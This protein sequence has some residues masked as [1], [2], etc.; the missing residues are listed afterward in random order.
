MATL[1]VRCMTNGPLP[2]VREI[3]SLYRA[4][5][6]EVICIVNSRFRDDELAELD[7]V[8]DRIIRVEMLPGFSVGHYRAWERSLPSTAD[9]VLVVDHDE[10]PSASF[11]R[12]LPGLLD[13]EHVVSYRLDKRWLFPD[14]AHWLAAQPWCPNQS[15]GLI[16]NDPNILH[17]NSELHVGTISPFPSRDIEGA[18][19]HLTCLLT[20][21]DERREKV[22]RY[23]EAMGISPNASQDATESMYVP[24]ECGTTQLSQVPTEDTFLI[25][26]VLS[27]SNAPGRVIDAR[28]PITPDEPIRSDVVTYPEVAKYWPG[29]PIENSAYHASLT[30]LDWNNPT[31]TDSFTMKAG[32]SM[33]WGVRVTNE[34]SE[35]WPR[36]LREPPIAL[37]S[38]WR[39]VAKPKPG[40]IRR[41]LRRAALRLRK[42]QG[43]RSKRD[44][45]DGPRSAFGADVYPGETVTMQLEIRAPSR[46]GD[47]RLSIDVVHEGVRWFRSGISIPV[48]IEG[49]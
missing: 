21:V 23:R 45:I 33:Q 48:V 38:R 28:Q 46:V 43:E 37:G 36:E 11:L 9:W 18:L 29:R 17:F 5:A 8:A 41:R 30:L 13:V 14:S 32:S 10:V 35:I 6:D 7:G 19:Y 44:V 3:L 26:A 1:S 49:R 2:R 39:P 40:S 25:D 31:G 16:R 24:E 20:T 22:A 27:K 42:V 47:Y 4:V 12:N 34:G 15:P